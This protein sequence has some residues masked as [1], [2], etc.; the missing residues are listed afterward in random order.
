MMLV[1]ISV[2]TSV[3]NAI[4]VKPLNKGENFYINNIHD[5]IHHEKTF[6]LLINF[7]KHN[8]NILENDKKGESLLSRNFCPRSIWKYWLSGTQ[9]EVGDVCYVRR[10]IVS[11]MFLKDKL[12]AKHRGFCH[13]KI[14][15]LLLTFLYK[16]VSFRGK[17]SLTEES[18]I[19]YTRQYYPLQDL[20]RC[21]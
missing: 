14:L 21:L 15:F 3:L 11:L 16:N 7:E 17:K 18:L 2:D 9:P 8:I 19:S 13:V 6:V 5:F 10:W 12:F 1:A 20:L 4:K